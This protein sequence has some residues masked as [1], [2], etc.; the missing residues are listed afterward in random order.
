MSK[1]PIPWPVNRE[2]AQHMAM[3]KTENLM[4]AKK[5]RNENWM[6]EKL[7]RTGLKWSRQSRWGFRL[8][9]FWCHPLGIA[10]EVD[11]PE[12]NAKKDAAIDKVHLHRYGILVLMVRNRDEKE[13]EIAIEKIMRLELWQER[14]IAHGIKEIK[15]ASESHPQVKSVLEMRQTRL[16]LKEG[17]GRNMNHE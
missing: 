9:D 8:F 2:L 5:N 16:E 7:E 17:F 3:R 11:G 12:H 14:R 1:C 4:R 13:A 6:L 10:V 15:C